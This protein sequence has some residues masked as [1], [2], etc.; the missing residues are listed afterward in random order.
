LIDLFYL[1]GIK[2]V[3]RYNE[4]ETYCC[5]GL[6]FLSIFFEAVAAG[7]NILGY[8]N[9]AATDSCGNSLWV[10]IITSVILVI[11]PLLQLL[12]FNKQNSLLTTGLVSTYI[13][14]LALVSQ[15]SYGGSSCSNM[16]I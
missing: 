16:L 7:L 4:G 14:Y 11:L 5:F 9:F 3:K 8:I 1:A 10:N 12:N 13:A 6:V 2:L 15:F